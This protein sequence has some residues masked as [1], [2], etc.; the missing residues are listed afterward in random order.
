MMV[1]MFLPAKDIG[2]PIPP[3]KDV[4]PYTTGL[5]IRLIHYDDGIEFHVHENYEGPVHLEI[6]E[7]CMNETGLFLKNFAQTQVILN[8]Q[9]V[10]VVANRV[11]GGK[12]R[13]RYDIVE[14]VD[15]AT[16]TAKKGKGDGAQSE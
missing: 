2:K 4:G 5:E 10:K 6:A 15:Q 7:E 14:Q 11:R 8:H 13:G 1:P 16:V 3:R 9:V 12:P